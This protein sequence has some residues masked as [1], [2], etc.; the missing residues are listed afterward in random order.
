MLERIKNSILVEL[1]L[2]GGT[3]LILDL[4]GVII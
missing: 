3:I 1:G 4:T 2:C